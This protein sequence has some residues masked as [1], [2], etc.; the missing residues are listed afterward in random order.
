MESELIIYKREEIIDH[1]QKKFHAVHSFVYPL[2]DEFIRLKPSA[3]QWSVAE[4]LQ[5]LILSSTP[6]ATSLAVPSMVL[7]VFGLPKPRQS[8]SYIQLVNDYQQ[9][10]A[11]GFEAPK[12]YVPYVGKDRSGLLS[13]LKRMEE[14]LVRRLNKWWKEEELDKYMLPHP[15]LGKITMRELLFFT[16]Y[17]AEHH[18]KVI[19]KRAQEVSHKIV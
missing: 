16:I 8:R 5:H 9:A 18:L 10:L 13:T 1:L 12:E 7:W 14:K 15:S 3:E 2:S 4:N 6:V 11:N 19:E 17:H